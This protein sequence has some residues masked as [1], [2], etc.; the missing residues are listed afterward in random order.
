VKHYSNTKAN[1]KLP[2]SEQKQSNLNQATTSMTSSNNFSTNPPKS[3]LGAALT[4]MGVA[5]TL[6]TTAATLSSM[7]VGQVIVASVGATA[8]TVSLPAVVAI[9]A[10]GCLGLSV[11]SKLVRAI[12]SVQPSSDQLS[13]ASNPISMRT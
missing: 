10:A 11:G 6:S 13:P 8:V 2:Y 7:G 9:A 3:E 5:G 12:N 4:E 1:T